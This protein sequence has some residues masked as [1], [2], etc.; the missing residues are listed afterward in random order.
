MASFKRSTGDYD[1]LHV[2]KSP[3]VNLG[4][5]LYLRHEVGNPIGRKGEQGKRNSDYIIVAL[6]LG[7]ASGA[8]G[9]ARRSMCK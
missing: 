5:P 9:V 8:K 3:F 6:K 1:L 2:C 7:N 4:G